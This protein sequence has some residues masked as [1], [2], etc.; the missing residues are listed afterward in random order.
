ME[1]KV[2]II[3]ENNEEIEVQIL[4][5]F[6]LESN[7]KKYAIYT[8]NKEDSDSNVIVNVSL[9]EEDGD[10]IQLLEVDDN[11]VLKEIIDMIKEMIA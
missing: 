7:N 1:N 5:Y 6:T 3:N 11:E 2:K 4:K 9:V 8:D 10:N